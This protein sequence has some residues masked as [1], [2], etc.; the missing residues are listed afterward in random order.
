MVIGQGG[1]EHA[2]VRALKLSPSV[3]DVHAAPGSAGMA[4]DCVCH[5]GVK[6]ANHGAITSLC[7]ELK[8]DCVVVGPEV[9]LAEGLAD[10]LR[11][12][13]F[14]V[15]GPEQA[16]ARLESSKIFSKEFMTAA[17]VTTARYFVVD[18]VSS[19]LS[20]S[21]PNSNRRMF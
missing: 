3:S 4:R 20:R 11:A 1:R 10:S 13:G 2:L 19:C 6:P 18:S 7:A 8:I 9:P 21:G 14:A 16:A 12:R 17:G 15:V 5:F